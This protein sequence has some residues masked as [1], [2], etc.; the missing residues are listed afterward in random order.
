LLLWI[1]NPQASGTEEQAWVG[2]RPGDRLRMRHT[3]RRE[4]EVFTILG[5]GKAGRAL[6]AAWGETATLQPG[7]AT[8]E[9]FVLLAVPDDALAAL[10]ERFVGRCAHLSGSLNLPGVPCLHPLTSFNGALADWRGTP[11]A[12]T[13]EVPEF[14]REAFEQLG[15]LPFLLAP[16]QKARYHAAAVL[17]SGHAATLWLGAAR[18]LQDAGIDLP[19][20]GLEPL[21]RATL[22]NLLSR[23]RA[24]RTG[25]F[26]R[27]DAATI[28]RDAEAL[29]EAWREVFLKLGRMD[30]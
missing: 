17:T 10:A 28:A 26:A 29:P 15:F 13:G 9:G 21:A 14:L 6:A 24:G 20:R 23:G 25:P 8:P 5:R 2:L 27:E 4:T 11:L 12:L 16:E 19:G 30:V 1:Q 18:L 7:T 3:I 22:E